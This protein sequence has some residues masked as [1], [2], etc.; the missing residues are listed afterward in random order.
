MSYLIVNAGVVVNSLKGVIGLICLAFALHSALWLVLNA[1]LDFFYGF[2]PQQRLRF[3]FYY[4]P[5]DGFCA[6]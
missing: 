3:L 2:Y 1:F 4:G 6:T 5:S